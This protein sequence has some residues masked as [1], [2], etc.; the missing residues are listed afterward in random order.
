MEMSANQQRIVGPE[1][2]GTAAERPIWLSIEAG[3]VFAFMHAGEPARRRDTAVLICPPFGW[4]EMC[5]HR[6]RRAWARTLA[7]AGYPTLRIDFPGAG[8][9]SGVPRDPDRMAAWKDAVAGAADW[10]RSTFGVHRVAAIGI[11]VGGMM[12]VAATADGAP[13]DDLLLWAVP[14]RGRTMLR[15][16]RA[17]AGIVAARYPDERQVPLEGAIEVTGFVMT[18]QTAAELEQLD[19]T[20][21]ELSDPQRRRVL[22]IE[23][24]E[25][26]VDRRLREHLEETAVSVTVLKAADYGMLM[27]H[28][29]EGRV[30]T[31]TIEA[32]AEWLGL[33]TGPGPAA[34]P[35]A[36]PPALTTATVQGRGHSV[37]EEPIEL[38]NPAGHSFGVLSLPAAGAQEDVC[39]V[40]LNAGALRRI[41]PNRTWVELARHW[42]SRGVPAVRIDFEGIG[43]SDGDERALV[44]NRNLYSERMVSQ[45]VSLL[46]DLTK[47][48]LP[49]RFLLVGLCSGAYWALQTA[50]A[51]PRVAGSCMLNL[52][53]FYWSEELVAERDR[54]ETAAALRDGVV[55]RIARGEVSRYQVMRALRGMRGALRSGVRSVEGRQETEVGLAL[56]KLRDQGTEVLLALSRE[57]ALYDQFEREGRIARMDQWPNVSLERL[58]SS[59]HMMRAVWLQARVAELLDLT[60]EELLARSRPGGARPRVGAAAK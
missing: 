31:A 27:A 29:Q 43:D 34:R 46:D 56:D 39:A 45:T 17:Y 52:Y 50:L 28:P 44:S 58:E 4:E 3:P 20:K 35:V 25:L 33:E 23:R 48:G 54:R 8:E 22:L 2:W 7:A 40:L 14:A 47:R 21:L 12:A 10:L 57:E 24:D 6:A 11:G 1:A 53:S 15:E 59:D 60:L 5:S 19:L 18:D 9:S 36:P 37:I 16:L 32:S 42:A 41:G 49:S 26:G 55:K 38:A 51:D 13:I 30:P